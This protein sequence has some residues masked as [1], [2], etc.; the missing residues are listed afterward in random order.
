MLDPGEWTVYSG[1]FC[2]EV[3]VNW[4]RGLCLVVTLSHLSVAKIRFVYG[5]ALVRDISFFFFHNFLLPPYS[6]RPL[7]SFLFSTSGWCRLTHLNR[8]VELFFNSQLFICRT[9]IQST[10]KYWRALSCGFSYVYLSSS[11]SQEYARGEEPWRPSFLGEINPN[12]N[13][14][15]EEYIWDDDVECPIPDPPK[16][17]NS[18]PISSFHVGRTLSSETYR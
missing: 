8:A 4:V 12:F 10:Q 15:E 16:V 6:D 17:T 14:Y 11:H 9:L 13:L 2:V 18:N 3:V 1:S 7:Q 5:V